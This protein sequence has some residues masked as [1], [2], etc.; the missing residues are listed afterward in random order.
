MPFCPNCHCEY[1]LEFTRCSDCDIEL[2]ESLSEENYVERDRGELELVQ[3]ASFPNLMEAQMIQ[4]LL[5]ANGIES[6]LQSDFNAGAG[7]FTA[8]PNAVLVRKI[9]YPK[10]YEL[11]EQYFE[12]DQPEQDIDDQDEVD[13]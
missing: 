13:P 1:R 5:E 11:Y 3:L 6:M 8:S 12:G 2:V 4:E 9:D 7:S 10:G